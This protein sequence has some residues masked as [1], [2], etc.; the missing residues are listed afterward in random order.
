MVAADRAAR[1]DAA[2]GVVVHPHDVA[3]EVA[4]VGFFEARGEKTCV[5]GGRGPADGFGEGLLEL[6]RQFVDELGGLFVFGDF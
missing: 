6:G 4:H 3:Y 5:E 2:V 1:H